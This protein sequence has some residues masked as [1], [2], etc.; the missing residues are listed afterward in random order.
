M[1]KTV[2]LSAVYPSSALC[3]FSGLKLLTEN[4]PL[5]WE[6]K[7]RRGIAMVMG[8]LSIMRQI[9]EPLGTHSVWKSFHVSFIMGM[10]HCLLKVPKWDC[11]DSYFNRVACFESSFGFANNGMQTYFSSAPSFKSIQSII[12]WWS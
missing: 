10:I 7:M 4:S 9:L 8:K 6:A 3:R 11:P 1:G 2:I 12:V 5:G